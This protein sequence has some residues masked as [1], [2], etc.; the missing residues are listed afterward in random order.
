MEKLI[1]T[2]LS[3]I[4]G[5]GVVDGKDVLL[6][7]P[8]THRERLKGLLG[9]RYG[10]IVGLM[11]RGKK[12]LGWLNPYVAQ[13]D[14]P[15]PSNSTYSG[16]AMTPDGDGLIFVSS[17]DTPRFID[18]SDP[19]EPELE[20]VTVERNGTQYDVAVCSDNGYFYTLNDIYDYST[21]TFGIE[22]YKGTG[23]Q[24]P[25]HVNY[26]ASDLDHPYG[27]GCN[28]EGD[29]LITSRDGIFKVSLQDPENPDLSSSVTLLEERAFDVTFSEN[30]KYAYVA[31]GEEFKIVD[32]ENPNEPKVLGKLNVETLESRGYW[33]IV[34][35]FD[36]TK[37][38]V[39]REF[40]V[41]LNEVHI[42]DV[43]DPQNPELLLRIPFPESVNG[44]HFSKDDELLYVI[45]S[46][47]NA[48]TRKLTVLDYNLFVA[49]NSRSLFNERNKLYTAI[50]AGK[51]KGVLYLGFWDRERNVRG[52]D[53]VDV[54]DPQNVHAVEA[55]SPLSVTYE[56]FVTADDETMLGISNFDYNLTL[57]DI[58]ISDSPQIL[59][60]MNVSGMKD[61]VVASEKKR[62]YI[63]T[64]DTV[65]AI[66]FSNDGSLT[67]LDSIEVGRY[68]ISIA[69]SK[70]EKSLFIVDRHGFFVV[71]ASDDRNLTLTYS[72]ESMKLDGKAAISSDGNYL[73]LLIIDY[74]DDRKVKLQ[75]M[76]LTDFRIVDSD[77]LEVFSNFSGYEILKLFLSHDG[78]KL[79]A[80]GRDGNIVIFDTTSPKNPEPQTRLF[81]SGSLIDMALSLD[82]VSLYTIDSSGELIMYDMTL[83]E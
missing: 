44:A 21:H 82:D 52:I 46:N 74:D 2:I 39:I 12:P 35:S 59:D 62:V 23:S 36:G 33:R 71:D 3:D 28:A 68:G 8:V 80:G 6:F 73:Y 29:L 67:L 7:D 64:S 51:E 24:T 5:N 49:D 72:D 37:V 83:Y 30:G 9:H 27:I 16:L 61:M 19:F 79:I 58:S 47:S 45:H 55:L 69:L 81:S 57:F 48:S 32:V 70:D 20:S 78:K 77:T 10:E 38:A 60:S 17:D 54:S 15:K 26:V 13:I 41:T 18:V 56:K 75:T 43:T 65:S 76:D 50:G 63:L 34:R 22:V 25:N 42:I 31:A 14:L 11:H 4:D 40:T 53:V 66:D 1:S